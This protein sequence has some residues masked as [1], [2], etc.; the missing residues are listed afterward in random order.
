MLSLPRVL[1]R[2]LLKGANQVDF[3][4]HNANFGPVEP[5]AKDGTT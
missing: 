5:P 2:R 3:V 1:E 4:H